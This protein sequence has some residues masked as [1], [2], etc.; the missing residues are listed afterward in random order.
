M[1][2]FLVKN[3]TQALNYAVTLTVVTMTAL[4]IH[5]DL[6]E[7]LISILHTLF[8]ALPFSI[9]AVLCMKGIII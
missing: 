4:F 9:K 5:S 3:D 2:N 6:N 1:F 8:D 7:F